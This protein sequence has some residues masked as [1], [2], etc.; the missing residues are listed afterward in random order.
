MMGDFIFD[1]NHFLTFNFLE[2]AAHTT[3]TDLVRSNGGKR[4]TANM[5]ENSIL[6]TPWY[7]TVYFVCARR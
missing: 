2:T 4:R 6:G 7:S 3:E 5:K 1:R